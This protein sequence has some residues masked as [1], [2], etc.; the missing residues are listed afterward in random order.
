[1]WGDGVGK[2]K[3]GRASWFKVCLHQKS[4]IDA[5][6]DATA[7]AALK[8]A[9]SYFDTME[10]PAGLDPLALAVFASLKSCV[11]EAFND[12]KENSAKNKKNIAKRYA[13]KGVPSATTRTTGN[14]LIP[15]DTKGTEE[16]VSK[17]TDSSIEE[18]SSAV[19]ALG[20][21]EQQ[22]VDPKFKKWKEENP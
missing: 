18:Y 15:N 20:G 19:P 12:Y 16:D 8:A 6:P 11:D 5:V 7:G 22:W 14:H 10:D 17:E 21:G 2:K 4:L 1:M 3:P 13:N 9:L